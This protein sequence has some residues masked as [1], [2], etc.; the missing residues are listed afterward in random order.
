MK[1]AAAERRR[2]TD[3]SVKNGGTNMLIEEQ[4][5]LQV[6]YE[7]L[8]KHGLRIEILPNSGNCSKKVRNIHRSKLKEA[9]RQWAWLNLEREYL[10]CQIAKYECEED[11]VYT[12]RQTEKMLRRENI[13]GKE[14]IVSHMVASEIRNLLKETGNG[15]EL[16]DK[17]A[18]MMF[19]ESKKEQHLQ[20]FEKALEKCRRNQEKYRNGEIIMRNLKMEYDEMIQGTWKFINLYQ[21]QNNLKLS[22]SA[23]NRNQIQLLE[24]LSVK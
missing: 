17:I 9:V 4:L 6:I 15:K 11:T 3:E 5:K 2:G 14:Q 21:D 8:L 13:Y 19:L 10:D 23:E 20:R 12:S 18:E 22:D 7:L 16:A 24:Q 1:S